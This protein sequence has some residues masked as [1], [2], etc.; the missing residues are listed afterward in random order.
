MAELVALLDFGSNA[1]RFL[2]TSIRPGTG[3][4][5]LSEERVQTRLGG[6][7]PGHLA[8]AAVEDTLRAAHRFL[9]R[10]RNGN[11][12]APRVIAVATS[13]VRDADNRKLLLDVLERREGV[14]VRVLSGREEARLGAHAA[15]AGRRVDEGAI[16]DLGGGSLQLTRVRRGRAAV[17]ASLP[18]G[19]C[20]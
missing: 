9:S 6:G 4:R 13:A 16:A 5:I 10:V 3:F 19:G 20:G 18:L 17:F 14:S 15:L 1:A 11:G 7:R 8:R 2:L 12:H